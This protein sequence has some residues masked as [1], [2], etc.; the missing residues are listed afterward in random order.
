LEY[1][2]A[3][4]ALRRDHPVLRRRRYLTGAQPGEVAWFTAAGAP[5]TDAYWR[6]PASRTVA[7]LVDGS[8]EPDRDAY[9]RPMTDDDILVLNNGWWEPLPFILP[10]APARAG[11]P[12]A[13]AWRLELDTFTGT[14]R[15][16]DAAVYCEGASVIVGA[17]SLV[18]LASQRGAA[19]PG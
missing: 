15:P 7:L 12:A 8:A 4:I 18:L 2:A 5:M 1:T 16:S 10:P 19:A 14:V 3:L 17:R 13:S 6:S 11:A 9:G